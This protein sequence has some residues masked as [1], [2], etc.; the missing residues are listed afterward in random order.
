MKQIKT[1]KMIS[2]IRTTIERNEIIDLSYVR[3]HKLGFWKGFAI[4]GIIFLI[5]LDIF[6]WKALLFGITL[7]CLK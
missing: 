5:I 6:I 3:G 4:S 1:P 2:G 7:G